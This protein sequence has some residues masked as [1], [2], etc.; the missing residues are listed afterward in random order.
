MEHG[1]S[2]DFSIAI[3]NNEYLRLAAL[4]RL[5]KD[6]HIIKQQLADKMINLQ[7]AI[8]C[9]HF[10]ETPTDHNFDYPTRLLR[11]HLHWIRKQAE[12]L[13]Q[14]QELIE[15]IEYVTKLLRDGRNKGS[16]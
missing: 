9:L 1:H 5:I 8:N 6:G 12:V 4:H 11:S 16:H 2:L 10:K 14:N 7:E 13:K 3:F 15:E